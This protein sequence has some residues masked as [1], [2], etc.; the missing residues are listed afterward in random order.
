MV[1]AVR[2]MALDRNNTGKCTA[3]ARSHFS[4]RHFTVSSCVR[5]PS[6]YY[7]GH[8]E[9]SLEDLGIHLHVRE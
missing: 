8:C 2:E 3:L 9:V 5:S 7:C 1:K 6:M 4:F